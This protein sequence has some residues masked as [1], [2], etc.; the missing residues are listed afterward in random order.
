MQ[1]QSTLRWR[2]AP[3]GHEGHQVVH[4]REDALLHLASVLRA[5]DDHLSP[6]EG[7]GDGGRRGHAFGLPVAREDARVED[8]EGLV[9]TGLLKE[10]HLVLLRRHKH[11]LHEECVVGARRYHADGNAVV[12]VPAPKTINHIEPLLQVQVIHSALAIRQEGRVLQ[13]HVHLAPP[14]VVR[15][16]L[17]E[18]YALVQGR[19]ARLLAALDSDGTGG[20]DGTA[21]LVLQ[22]LLVEDAG[23]RVVVDLLHVQAELVHLLH[24][25]HPVQAPG[26]DL[27][28]ERR[29][30]LGGRPALELCDLQLL[31]QRGLDLVRAGHR[32]EVALALAC[33]GCCRREA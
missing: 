18:D 23:R 20:D 1:R 28:G 8:H 19:P 12:L 6:L 5:Q 14:D 17:L 13:L 22:R 26:A 4:D 3:L 15:G 24:D 7:H 29:L 27:H 30:D 25:L 9:R 32:P 31:H 16:R 10:V 33:L 11:I 21:R 2:Q